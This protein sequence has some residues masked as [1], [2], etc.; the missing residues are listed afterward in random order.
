MTQQETQLTPEETKALVQRFYDEGWNNN[1]LSV[2]D[3][4][5]AEDFTEYPGVPG[6]TGREGFRQLNVIFKGA[7]P[8]LVVTVDQM[9]VEGDR[10]ACRWTSTGTHEGELFGI[11]PTGSKVKVTATLIYRIENGQLKEGWINRDD[12]GLM[13]QLGVVPTPG[14]E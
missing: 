13:R 8:D 2:Y 9:I 10:I 11:P 4:L 14:A 12:L 5:V 3:E 6:L 1:D 7:M